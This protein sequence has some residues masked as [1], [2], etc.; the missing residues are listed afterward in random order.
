VAAP[1]KELTI[2]KET[3]SLVKMD[4]ILVL[5]H[6]AKS[7]VLITHVVALIKEQT[8]M[9]ETHSLPKMDA[10]LVLAILDKFAVL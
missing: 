5:A 7:L 4:V 3:L 10:T 2:M 8:I 6:L 9:K 1:I